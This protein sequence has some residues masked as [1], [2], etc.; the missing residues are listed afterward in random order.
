MLSRW[1]KNIELEEASAHCDIPCGIYDPSKAIQAA[2][3]VVRMTNLLVE[4]KEVK[5]DLQWY[6]EVG[7]YI[8]SKEEHAEM[9]KHEVRVIWG[10]FFKQPQFEKYPDL[11]ALTHSI[12]LLGSKVKQNVSIAEARELLIKVNQFA[13]IFWE[14]KGKEVNVIKAPYAPFE[15]V[16]YPVL[17]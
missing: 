11:H 8:A 7:R 2:L 4:H 14:V 3:T 10:D 1:L 13:T 12:M 9:V 17:E 15:P 16:V 6:N 5:S